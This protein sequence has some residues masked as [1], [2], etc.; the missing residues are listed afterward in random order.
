MESREEMQRIAQENEEIARRHALNTPEIDDEIERAMRTVEAMDSNNNNGSME[1]EQVVQA[2]PPRNSVEQV[3]LNQSQRD[4]N[5]R[6]RQAR[7]ERRPLQAIDEANRI[8]AIESSGSITP[9]QTV[10]ND[11]SYPARDIDI[12]HLTG[13]NE[14]EINGTFGNLQPIKT[15]KSKKK[16]APSYSSSAFTDKIVRIAEGA[17]GKDNVSL[18][19]D[20]QGSS[21]NSNLRK[22]LV[23]KWDFIQIRNRNNITHD[24]KDIYIALPLNTYGTKFQGSF[25]GMRGT[26]TALENFSGYRHSHLTPSN[27]FFQAFCTGADGINDLWAEL[28]LGDTESESFDIKFEGFIHQMESFLSYESL[29]GVPYFRITSMNANN[30]KRRLR[31]NDVTRGFTSFLRHIPMSTVDLAMDFNVGIVK[32]IETEHLHHV[33]AST[34]THHQKRLAN[35]Q[36]VDLGVSESLRGAN[37]HEIHDSYY[38]FKGEERQ[39]VVEAYQEQKQD[40]VSSNKLYAN[41]A[42]SKKYF[43]A[44]EDKGRQVLQEFCLKNFVSNEDEEEREIGRGKV[45][46]T[47]N[48]L[49]PIGSTGKRVVGAVVLENERGSGSGK[50]RKHTDKH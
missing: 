21:A 38:R 42:I 12:S 11:N 20:G 29:E 1:D 31:P 24:I 49:S 15:A 26:L 25:A 10:I 23:L 27:M 37:S 44:I 30:A 47:G 48:T 39:I 43:K 19:L 16:V 46:N 7:S 33:M 28:Q 45:F 50:A 18:E 17:L 36:Y 4:Y 13:L 6:V 35:G 5:D 41:D 32:V 34:T 22:S 8:R 14:S 2:G 40:E 9:I 3:P